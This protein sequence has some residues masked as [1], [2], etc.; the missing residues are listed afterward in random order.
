MKKTVY[1]IIVVVAFVLQLLRGYGYFDNYD[2]YESGG[3]IPSTIGVVTGA[4]LAAAAT[5]VI[6][7]I[8]NMLMSKL[9]SKIKK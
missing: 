7:Y 4:I 9:Q 6:L 1:G 3:A 8:A 5:A 2:G